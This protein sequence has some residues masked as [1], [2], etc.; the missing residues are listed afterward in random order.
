MGR[1]QRLYC[2]HSKESLHSVNLEFFYFHQRCL[3]RRLAID[4][5]KGLS[6]AG[7]N[8]KYYVAERG[9]CLHVLPTD[10]LQKSRKDC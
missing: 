3:Y 1:C 9:S 7:T 6:G 2:P 8:E 5:Q 10:D 4:I